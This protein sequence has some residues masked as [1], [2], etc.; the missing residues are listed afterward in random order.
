ML[1]G[2]STLIEYNT[3]E[4]IVA[5]NNQDN[6]ELSEDD[7]K[8]ASRDFDLEDFCNKMLLLDVSPNT[9]ATL[10]NAFLGSQPELK[11]YNV[12]VSQLRTGLERVR[13]NAIKSLADKVVHGK[14]LFIFREQV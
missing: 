6:Y 3:D 12:T 7:A 10:L 2:D 4:E 8:P 9:G 13:S 11:S 5:D 1:R 14:N